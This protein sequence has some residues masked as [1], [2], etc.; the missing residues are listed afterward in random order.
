MG[1]SEAGFGGEYSETVQSVPD[2]SA[3]GEVRRD[4]RPGVGGVVGEG[5]LWRDL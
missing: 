3:G 4:R 1:V 2:E 5:E